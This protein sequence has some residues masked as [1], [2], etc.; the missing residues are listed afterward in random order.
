MTDSK[1]EG[2]QL[3]KVTSLR[4]TSSQNCEGASRFVSLIMTVAPPP[5]S[6]S[7]ACSMDASNAQEMKNADRKSVPT[8]NRCPSEKTLF[9]K[10]ACA[11]AT[12]FGCPDEPDV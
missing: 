10:L 11:T 12:P 2:T 6:G 8:L 7:I 9:A 1:Y 3:M 4:M 5:S